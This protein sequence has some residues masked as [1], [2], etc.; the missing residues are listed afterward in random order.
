MR[1]PSSN[2]LCFATASFVLA[3]QALLA[4]TA[5]AQKEADGGTGMVGRI[6]P[7]SSAPS[8]LK[9]LDGLIDDLY[10]TGDL[11]S[12]RRSW[13]TVDV[14]RLERAANDG[15]P[16][17]D[18]QLFAEG[19]GESF[20][21]VGVKS[22]GNDLRTN[23]IGANGGWRRFEAG[24]GFSRF[25]YQYEF[26]T[27]DFKGPD[28]LVGGSEQPVQDFIQNELSYTH[29]SPM[30]GRSSGWAGLARVRSGMESSAEFA[31]SLT[32]QLLGGL[33]LRANKDLIWNFGALVKV[34][35]HGDVTILPV[36]GID[37]QLSDRWEVST[38]GPGLELDYELGS[39]SNLFLSGLYESRN[40]RLDDKGPQQLS[41]G[42]IE[43]QAVVLRGGLRWNWAKQDGGFPD[44]RLQLYGGLVPWRELAF[45]SSNDQL[46]T[47]LE[48]D[49]GAVFGLS[50]QLGF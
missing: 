21:D 11:E 36:I 50:F 2:S 6:G 42:S 43:D 34:E 9:N 24:G 19:Y 18:W 37:W 38:P 20:L 12:V 44:R 25:A 45:W 39:R 8:G 48:L 10:G 31:D 3:C 16:P 13:P 4:P 22:S 30:Q 28:L 17:T 7:K 14:L 5:L 26:A 49:T 32:Y 1:C 33:R 23:R 46:V 47:D 15:P 27:Y 29:V 40:Y 35:L 41:G